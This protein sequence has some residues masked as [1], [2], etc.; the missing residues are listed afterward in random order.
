MYDQSGNQSGML[1]VDSKPLLKTRVTTMIKLKTYNI[2]HLQDLQH[3]QLAAN[4]S[5]LSNRWYHPLIER[6]PDD[7]HHGRGA[8]HFLV[9][10]IAVA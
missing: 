2:Q 5:V 9:T 8:A 1:I 3:L 6:S 7:R 10:V 4:H